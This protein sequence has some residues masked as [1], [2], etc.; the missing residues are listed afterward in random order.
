M[1]RLQERGASLFLV[2]N[3]PDFAIGKATMEEILAIQQ[4]FLNQLTHAGVQFQAF[5]YCYHHPNGKV[6]GYRG[7]CPCRKP[8]TFF[9]EQAEQEFKIRLKDS[10]MVGDRDADVECGRRAGCKTILIECPES[11]T[12]RG[13]SKPDYTVTDFNSAARLLEKLWDGGI[14]D[15]TQG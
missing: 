12:H 2:S 4:L 9:L 6:A 3:Q 5:Y 8:G 14:D 13:N 11:A 1:R 10:W 15:S 7:K